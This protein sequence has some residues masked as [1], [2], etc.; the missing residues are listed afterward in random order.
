M[1]L[2]VDI[3]NKILDQIGDY[4]FYQVEYEKGTNRPIE[5]T[6][7]VTNYEAFVN[8]ESYEF[9]TS[10][11]Y[12]SG[13]VSNHIAKWE[14]TLILKFSVE[15][16]MEDF[17]MNCMDDLTFTTDKYLVKGAV[18]SAM[19]GHPVQHGANNGTLASIKINLQ[20]RR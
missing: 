20:V 2:R 9:T 14:I 18:K 11:V 6:K 3:Q 12:G 5:T 10:P 13:T 4:S 19:V 1:G 8:E 16:V 17:L 15:V 7:V